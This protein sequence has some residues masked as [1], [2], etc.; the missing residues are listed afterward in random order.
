MPEARQ[1]WQTGAS[2]ERRQ[3]T[4]LARHASQA[5]T[6]RVRFLGS[7][8][9]ADASDCL[10]F[11]FEEAEALSGAGVEGPAD[12]TDASVSAAAIIADDVILRDESEVSMRVVVQPVNASEDL[13]A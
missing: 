2:G 4:F 8:P 3:R 6:G 11:S 7:D 1:F 5:L 13:I 9:D 12:A 10:R